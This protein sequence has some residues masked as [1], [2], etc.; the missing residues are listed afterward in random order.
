MNLWEMVTYFGL[1]MVFIGRSIT[2]QTCVPND[3]GGKN[4]F[5]MDDI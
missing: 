1:E 3:F 4:G 2:V 5:D